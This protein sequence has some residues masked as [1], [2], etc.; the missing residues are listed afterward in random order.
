MN[1]PYEIN[2]GHTPRGYLDIFWLGQAGF[3]FR[4]DTGFTIAVD[5]YLTDCGERMRG[6]KRLS[7]KLIAP[8]EFRPDVLVTSH[9]HFD[10]FDYDA[11][12]IIAAGSTRFI[13]PQ[14]C[15]KLLVDDICVA[16]ERIDTVGYGDQILLGPGTTFTAFEADHGDMAPDAFGTGLDFNGLRVYISGDT[17][18]R[19][20]IMDTAAAFAPHVGILSINGAFGNMN[21]I[22]GAKAAGQLG[23][24]LA[25]P[26][27]FWTFA[28]HGGN[29][30]EF[31]ASVPQYAP[32]CTPRLMTQGERLRLH[33]D[34]YRRS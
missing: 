2:Y 25:I 13:C 12:P 27:H 18:L 21:A 11:I 6:F 34:S 19:P 26:C 10:H 24:K 8:S 29:P 3:L 28:E 31:M 20:T 23:V 4:T 5:P 33:M 17:A 9:H 32:D 22:E 30:A 15:R 1:L 7:P 14:S 16:E